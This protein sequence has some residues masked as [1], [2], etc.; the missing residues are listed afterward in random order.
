MDNSDT[1]RELGNGG[2][3]GWVDDKCGFKH[4]IFAVFVEHMAMPIMQLPIPV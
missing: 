2:K 1:N 4:T 3:E